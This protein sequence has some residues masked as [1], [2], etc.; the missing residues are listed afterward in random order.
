[1]SIHEWINEKVYLYIDIK[2]YNS[3]IEKNEILHFMTTWMNLEGIILSK[4]SQVE[5]DKYCM[6]C[7][8]CEI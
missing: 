1:M 8:I 3:A 6:I 2:E 4:I 7:F 5:K